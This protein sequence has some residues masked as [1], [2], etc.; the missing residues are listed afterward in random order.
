MVV[1]YR[2]STVIFHTERLSSVNK[3]LLFLVVLS[4]FGFWPCNFVSSWCIDCAELKFDNVYALSLRIFHLVLFFFLTE[5]RL[6][7]FFN[8]WTGRDTG[9]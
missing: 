6:T 8:S 4:C 7:F 3:M 9:K 2:P 1:Q 5:R